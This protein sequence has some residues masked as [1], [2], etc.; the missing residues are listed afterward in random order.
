MCSLL[1]LVGATLGLFWCSWGVSMA[2]RI[3]KTFYVGTLE[4]PSWPPRSSQQPQA[5]PQAPRWRGRGPHEATK[6]HLETYFDLFH[7]P[8]FKNFDF[9]SARARFL[10]NQGLGSQDALK[11][12]WGLASAPFG[13]S[14]GPLGGSFG[15]LGGSMWHP[16]FPNVL[17]GHP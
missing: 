4:P 1:V 13:C 3:S 5:A 9:A 12:V 16:E 7:P 15:A 10:K 11:G 8:I 14:W 17:L 2:Q 6:P